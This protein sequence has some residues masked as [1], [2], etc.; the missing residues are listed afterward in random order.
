LRGVT[1]SGKSLI[2]GSAAVLG[3]Y[4]CLQHYAAR[5]FA[6]AA[7]AG[8][9]DRADAI[10]EAASD[11]AVTLPLIALVLLAGGLVVMSTAANSLSV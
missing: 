4:Y 9:F 3:G 10:V 6:D 2:F 7:I 11:A 8:D 5:G 1:V